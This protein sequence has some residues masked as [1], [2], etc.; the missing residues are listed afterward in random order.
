MTK[1]ELETS[2]EATTH[3][4][5]AV[6]GMVASEMTLNADPGDRSRVYARN[7]QTEALLALVLVLDAQLGRISRG[8]I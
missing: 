3:Y 7:A 1:V 6:D 2:D 8:R 5:N 4:N